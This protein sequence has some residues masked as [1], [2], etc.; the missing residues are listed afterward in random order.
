MDTFALVKIFKKHAQASF[1]DA[2][3]AHSC[4]FSKNYPIEIALAYL[5]KAIS[6][7]CCCDSLYY[8]KYE[9]LSEMEYENYS[10]Q[11]DVFA[12]EFLNNVKTNHSH[13]WTDLEFERLKEIYDNSDFSS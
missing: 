5:N 12:R 8:T 4:I 11:F 3:N 2:Q 9:Q 1:Y 6:E 7:H 13:Q 10:H